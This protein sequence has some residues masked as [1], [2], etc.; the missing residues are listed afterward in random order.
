[1]VHDSEDSL[2]FLKIRYAKGE[3]NHAEYAKMKS[4]LLQSCWQEKI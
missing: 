3:I 1:M 4:V 2:E